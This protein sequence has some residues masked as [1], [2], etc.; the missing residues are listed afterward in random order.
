MRGFDNF[1][2]WTMIEEP[3]F[4]VRLIWNGHAGSKVNELANARSSPS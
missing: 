4:K 2:R 3:G 1:N